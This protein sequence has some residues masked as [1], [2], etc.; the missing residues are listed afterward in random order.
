MF[1]FLPAGVALPSSGMLGGFNWT[2]GTGSNET[3][4]IKALTPTSVI[5][6]ANSIDIDFVLNIIKITVIS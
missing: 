1:P 6:L 3:V 4:V 2:G 5:K